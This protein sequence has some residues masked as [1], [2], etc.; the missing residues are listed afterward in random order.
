MAPRV[1]ACYACGNVAHCKSCA[2]CMSAFY[3]TKLCQREHW[4]MHRSMCS[5]TVKAAGKKPKSGE[6]KTLSYQLGALMSDQTFIE[7]VFLATAS[8]GGKLAR[9]MFIPGC[10][11]VVAVNMPLVATISGPA[12]RELLRR[13]NFDKQPDDL[14]DV[15]FAM[16][17]FSDPQARQFLA[18]VAYQ[19]E[20]DT[21]GL[22]CEAH[23]GKIGREGGQEVVSST[24]FLN[25]DSLL[26]LSKKF[27]MHTIV[28]QPNA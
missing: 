8:E 6:Q 13:A 25:E 5:V 1:C 28:V 24:S 18:S 9:A 16:L 17:R 14:E 7:D 21:C 26:A 20:K 12:R 10:F 27:G 2:G 3:C 23:D 15:R 11:I 4:K 22:V 19:P